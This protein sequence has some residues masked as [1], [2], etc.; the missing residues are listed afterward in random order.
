M[1]ILDT[2]V[3]SEIMRLVPDADV[4]AWFTAQPENASFLTATTEAELRVGIAILPAGKRRDTLSATLVAI[5]EVDFAARI[6]PFDTPAAIAY[7]AIV[8]KRQKLGL[9]ISQS[10]AQIAAIAKSRK[11]TLATRNTRDFAHCDI[12]LVNPWLTR[13]QTH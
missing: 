12:P 7:A 9:P 2:N 11:A 8:A 5:L 6:L 13:Y 4:L 3:V 1:I 10:D